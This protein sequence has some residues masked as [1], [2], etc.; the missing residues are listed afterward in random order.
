MTNK[1]IDVRIKIAIISGIF[2]VSAYG[3]AAYLQSPLADTQFQELDLMIPG[4][5]I[6]ESG[7]E[8]FKLI[9]WK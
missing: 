3:I 9:D 1:K 6:Y 5:L 4:Q 2:L 7:N 8:G